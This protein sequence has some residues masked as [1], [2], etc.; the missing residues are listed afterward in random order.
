MGINDL[1]LSRWRD[2]GHILTDSLW[3]LGNRAK[4][5]HATG[6]FHG[7]FVPQIPEQMLLRYTKEGDT[8]LD[9]FTGAG[10][11]FYECLR[12]KRNFIGVDINEATI[13]ALTKHI[14][15]L[16]NVDINW[17]LINGDSSKKKIKAEIR[18]YANPVQ[19]VFMHPP[20][21][22]IIKFSELDDDLSNTETLE[23]FL[24]MFNLVI[25]NAYYLLEK[26]RYATIVMGDKYHKGEWIPLGFY[27][28]K[29]AMEAG[30]TLK[31]ICVKDIAGNEKGKGVNT[32]LWR[33]RSLNGGFY[34]F[35]HEYILILK[36]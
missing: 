25:K 8:V 7:N 22:D 28:M 10:T 11:T 36:K 33:Y 9:L 6:D 32:N 15:T 5:L 26:G 2:Y 29:L 21:W 30:F 18:K 3:L 1:D 23:E 4:R 34:I 12:L 19:H 24:E 20:Y 13:E 27:C 17:N 35:K 14:A 16:D 31:S